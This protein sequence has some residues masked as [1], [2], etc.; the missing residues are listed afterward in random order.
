MESIL[1]QVNRK[2]HFISGKQK[3]KAKGRL[4][5]QGWMYILVKE[6]IS[7]EEK[8]IYF[9]LKSNYHF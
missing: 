9:K 7:Q 2:L 6:T 1:F 5:T 4:K 8:S 3:I